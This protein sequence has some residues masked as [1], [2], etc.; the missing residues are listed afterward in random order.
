MNNVTRLKQTSCF[1]VAAEC[2][3]QTSAKLWL[4]ITLIGM[5][6][7]IIYL[8]GYYGSIVLIRGWN[9][10][11]ATYMPHGFIRGDTT[12]NIAIGTHIIVA[13]VAMG[14][15]S[16]EFIPRIRI[17]TPGVHRWTGRLFL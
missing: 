5:G 17:Q 8:G 14:C 3:L 16:L 13:M 12:G 6:M 4:V 15:G 10:L 7:F 1:S 11:Y 2:V 9:G